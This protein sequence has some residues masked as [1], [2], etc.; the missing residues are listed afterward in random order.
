MSVL[1]VWVPVSKCMRAVPITGYSN[2][3]DTDHSSCIYSVFPIFLFSVFLRLRS[4]TIPLHVWNSFV[5]VSPTLRSMTSSG[6][7]SRWLINLY[8]YQTLLLYCFAMRRIIKSLSA[9]SLGK[10]T[11]LY[12]PEHAI[13]PRCPG[14]KQKANETTLLSVYLGST[15]GGRIYHSDGWEPI[16]G[17][18]TTA[19]KIHRSVIGYPI[20]IYLES[21]T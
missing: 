12:N 20:F 13:Q 11:I 6:R 16:V 1:Q 14:A 3:R 19:F 10:N 2:S 4:N 17:Q 7:L 5:F 15:L 9:E 21:S 8:G 18:M